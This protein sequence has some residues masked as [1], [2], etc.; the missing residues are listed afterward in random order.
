[1]EQSSLKKLTGFQLVKK[2]PH[3]MDPEGWLSHSHVP[4]T[5]PYPEPDRYS[6]YPT[7]HF[8]KINLNIILLFTPGYPKWSI[9]VRFPHQNPVHG[10]PLTHKRSSRFYHWTILGEEY[11]SLSSSL[12]SF[13]HS[14][15]TLSLKD[16]LFT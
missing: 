3:F 4:A 5:C 16:F 2:F 13:L 11:R 12:C 10:S 1:M 14:P 9:S 8:L 7:S 15:V 6:P